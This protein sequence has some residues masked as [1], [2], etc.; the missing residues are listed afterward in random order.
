MKL[1]NRHKGK[2]SLAICMMFLA[3]G[4]NG[5]GKEAVEEEAPEISDDV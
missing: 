3:A 5:C 1:F 2:L 4:L